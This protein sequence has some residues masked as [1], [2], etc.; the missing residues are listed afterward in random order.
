MIIPNNS[1]EWIITAVKPNELEIESWLN[2]HITDPLAIIIFKSK[3][4]TI[5]SLKDESTA[6]ML[7]LK[8]ADKIVNIE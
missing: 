2:D 8:F 3:K 7:K 5:I 6:A 4:Y 1:P